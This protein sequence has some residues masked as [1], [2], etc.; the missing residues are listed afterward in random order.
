[1]KKT[2]GL[3]FLLSVVLLG[4]KKTVTTP[5][6]GIFRGTF[7]KVILSSSDTVAQGAC[8]ISLNEVSETYSMNVD[9]ADAAP[10][11][12][13]GSYSVLN[14]ATMYFNVNTGY[15]TYNFDSN[16]VLDTVYNYS[17]DNENLSLDFTYMDSVK[18]YYYFDRY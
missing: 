14:S 5:N 7:S 1:M 13:S 4:C 15:P 3:L 2:V 8:T 18:Y 17:F 11:P 12:C 10:Y 16:F 6:S 9:T